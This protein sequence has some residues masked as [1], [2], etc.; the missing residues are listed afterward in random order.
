MERFPQPR[1][2]IVLERSDEAQGGRGK[3]EAGGKST[4]GLHFQF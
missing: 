2:P 3:R 1:D 4:A